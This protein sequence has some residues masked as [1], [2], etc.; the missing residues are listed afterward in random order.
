MDNNRF[1]IVR[2]LN[3]T[4]VIRLPRL[5]K[6][7]WLI[8]SSLLFIVLAVAYWYCLP[9]PLFNDPLSRVIYSRQG[10]LMGARIAEDQQWRFPRQ[11]LLPEKFTAA[12]IEFEDQRFYQHI[13]VDPWAMMRATKQ[14]VQAGRVVS[15]GSTLSMQVIRLARKNP[16]RTYLEKILEMIRAT[17]LEI[18]YSKSEI[19]SLYAAHAPFGGNVVGLEAAAWRYFSRSAQNLSW[20]ESALLAVRPN[21]PAMM[22]PGRKRHDLK[23]KRDRLLNRLH[24][25][26]VINDIELSLALSESIPEKPQALP[27]MAPHLL[28]TLI[29][30]NPSEMRF[31]STI[32]DIYQRQV[33][34]IV[35]NHNEILSQQGIANAAVVVIDNENF[36]VLAYVG[37][38]HW[39]TQN[40]KGYAVDIVQRPRSTGSILKPLLFASMLQHGELLPTTLVP[41]IPTHMNGYQPENYDHGYR[42]AVPA[43][44]ALARSLNIPA[45]RML[46]R[47]GVRRFYDMLTNMGMTSLFRDADDYGLTLIL[48]GAEGSLWDLT[49]MYANMAKIAKQNQSNLNV[50]YR[51]ARLTL[52]QTTITQSLIDFKGGA[53]WLTLQ[54]LLDVNRPANESHWRN[55]SSSQKI[56]WKTGTSY[57]LRDGWAIGSNR[58]FTVG[59][60]VGNASGEGRAGLTGLGTAAPIMFDVF[61]FLPSTTWFERPDSLLTKVEVCKEDGLLSNGHCQ[62]VS[63]WM[64]VEAGFQTVSN[65][66][67]LLHLDHSGRWQVNSHCEPVK[68]MQHKAWFNL[69]PTQAYYYKRHHSKYQ[70]MPAYRRDCLQ[71]QKN[72]N[73]FAQD[74]TMELVYPADANTKIYIPI[75]LSGIKSQ[76]VF[77]AMHSDANAILYWHLNN[78]YLGETKTFH[79][80]AVDIAPGKY[81]LTLID[82]T[83]NRVSRQIEVLGVRGS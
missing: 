28:A 48:G 80:M 22:H 44:I 20:A 65:H 12:L 68:R 76:T 49:Q 59:V 24:V 45:V 72:L 3:L 13:G 42:G 71:K 70:P 11:E 79:R 17:R 57:G 82:E 14:N 8:L 60:W 43:K 4:K 26:G 5:G 66:Y 74:R 37:N 19:L 63:Q 69:P 6:R 38:S 61:N 1:R 18:S 9:E 15:G 25:Q 29:Q 34:R 23:A 55:F 56:A 52:K 75:D 50:T 10:N 53:A 83:G 54:A 2:L 39:S 64:P 58:H 46:H 47:H 81:T 27:Q 78:R 77:E 51:K 21:N 40:H 7:N 62:T 30:S 35:E 31:E 73:S 41:D 33:S 36:D 16:G 32:D 67:K